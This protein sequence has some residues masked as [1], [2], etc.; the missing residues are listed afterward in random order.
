[1][2]ATGLVRKADRH[3]S[4]VIGCKDHTC[5]MRSCAGTSDEREDSVWESP[6]IR[7]ALRKGLGGQPE[8]RI[9]GRK[10]MKGCLH[11]YQYILHVRTSENS[12]SSSSSSS[13]RE[14]WGA[15]DGRAGTP[16][17]LPAQSERKGRVSVKVCRPSSGQDSACCNCT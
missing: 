14:A 12:S 17:S 3:E 9:G 7:Q 15:P 16:K 2:R 13:S 10:H 8:S 5:G 1:M 11:S 6:V 4:S